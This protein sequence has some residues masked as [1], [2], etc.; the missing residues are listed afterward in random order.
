M[1]ITNHNKRQRW[2]MPL[3]KGGNETLLKEN[4][5]QAFEPHILPERPRGYPGLREAKKLVYSCTVTC[6]IGPCSFHNARSL[7]PRI[8]HCPREVQRAWRTQRRNRE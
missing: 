8:V 4:S 2:N 5:V 7:P 1:H 3:M 6:R